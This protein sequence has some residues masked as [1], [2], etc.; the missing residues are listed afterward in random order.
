MS[1]NEWQALVVNEVDENIFLPG[2]KNGKFKTK[3]LPVQ[4]VKLPVD[5]L[6]T[7][8]VLSWRWDGEHE[9]QGSRNAFCAVQQTKKLGIK[10]LF[11][12][13]ISIDQRL[14]GDDLL[15]H[16]V[17]FS[18]LYKT[19]PV[20][21]AYDIV[22]GD[23]EIT[24]YRPWII[25]EAKSFRYNPTRIIYVGHQNAGHTDIMAPKKT[26]AS[27]FEGAL[28]DI[29]GR[30]FAESILGIHGGTF[31]ITSISDLKFIIPSWARV[32]EV[33]YEQ[34]SRGKMSRNDYLLTAAICC[35]L[36]SPYTRVKNWNK[37]R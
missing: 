3:D 8:A 10:Y 16:V 21:A 34:M 20:I 25:S 2:S 6:S 7:I 11:I 30:G 24:V 23:L 15:R 5:D 26:S 13:V 1:F 27:Y 33:A 4:T 36:K 19:I 31:D 35:Q 22:R 14:S 9:L 32:F 28:K 37:N 17:A 12:D 18:Q 29:W